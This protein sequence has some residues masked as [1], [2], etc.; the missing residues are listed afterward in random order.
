MIK[1][2]LEKTFLTHFWFL[3]TSL[4]THKTCKY[5]FEVLK[6]R[7]VINSP[8]EFLPLGKVRNKIREANQFKLWKTPFFV[9]SAKSCSQNIQ[10]LVTGL[11][12]CAVNILRGQK[13]NNLFAADCDKIDEFQKV[14]KLTCCFWKCLW[15]Y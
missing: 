9:N 13:H 7:K 1:E 6:S 10:S 4:R 15:E 14:A 3:N 8:L 11:K 2:N 5:S 12:I